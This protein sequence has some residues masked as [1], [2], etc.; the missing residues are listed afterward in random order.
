VGEKGKKIISD[1]RGP[2][3]DYDRNGHAGGAILGCFF[4]D[5][6][7]RR[8]GHYLATGDEQGLTEGDSEV[9]DERRGTVHH[10]AAALH[11]RP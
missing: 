10:R 4:P 9:V 8:R 5:E 2:V 1:M 11:G 3:I 6:M 7:T